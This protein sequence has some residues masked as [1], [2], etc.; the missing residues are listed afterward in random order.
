MTQVIIT[1]VNNGNSMN[2]DIISKT[3]NKMVVVIENTVVR[4]VL[5]RTQRT[6][7]YIGKLHGME[8]SCFVK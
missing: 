3:D 5:T 4:L 6:A 1:S 7:P 2:A 8:F